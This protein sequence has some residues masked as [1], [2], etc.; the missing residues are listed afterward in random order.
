MAPPF[1]I[2]SRAFTARFRTTSSSSP[3]STSTGHRSFAN[4]NVDMHIAPEAP[5]EEFAHAADLASEVHGLG[6]QFCRR[7]NARS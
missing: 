1:G 4:S 3:G 7:E 6:L 2:A 5:V